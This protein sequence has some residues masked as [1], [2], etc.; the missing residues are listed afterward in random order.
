MFEYVFAAMKKDRMTKCP[1][2]NVN[3]SM[4]ERHGMEVDYCPKCRG[5]WFDR[6]KVGK[7]VE[8]V[9]R[10]YGPISDKSNCPGI[11][12][13]AALRW[14]AILPVYAYL[15]RRTKKPGGIDETVLISVPKCEATRARIAA[16]S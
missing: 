5:I 12:G 13:Y 7:I 6:S 2:C 14:V 3:I 16:C 4:I 11:R 9:M 15:T 8:R 1:V 10:E